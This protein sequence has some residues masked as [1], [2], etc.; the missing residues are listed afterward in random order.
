MIN[1]YAIVEQP[2]FETKDTKPFTGKFVCVAIVLWDGNGGYTPQAGQKI[3]ALSSEE[4][5]CV[6][7]L[8]DGAT[9]TLPVP[10]VVEPKI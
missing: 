6:G 1:R 10:V 2:N 8:Y 3:V 9:W 7:A 4:L 5:C